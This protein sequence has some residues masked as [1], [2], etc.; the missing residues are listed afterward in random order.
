MTDVLNLIFLFNFMNDDLKKAFEIM[1]L[2]FLLCKKNFLTV[3]LPVILSP[4]NHTYYVFYVCRASGSI[5]E[6]PNFHRKLEL[7]ENFLLLWF[8]HISLFPSFLTE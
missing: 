7:S 8:S 5:G 3:N 6:L 4:V 1:T 2:L